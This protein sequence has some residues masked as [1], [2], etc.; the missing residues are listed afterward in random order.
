MATT[1][2]GGVM[3][4]SSIIGSEASGSS[5]GSGS[6]PDI[7]ARD[8]TLETLNLRFCTNGKFLG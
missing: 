8:T 3:A 7:P 1:V 5:S 4:M 2:D 6:S